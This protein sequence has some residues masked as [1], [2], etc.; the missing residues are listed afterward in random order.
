MNIIIA[1]SKGWFKIK[2]SLSKKLN[3][4]MIITSS[5]IIIIAISIYF[6]PTSWVNIM[7]MEES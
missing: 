6:H 5:R 7:N 3:I 2:P 1:D 4:K